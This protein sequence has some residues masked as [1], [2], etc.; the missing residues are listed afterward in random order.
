MALWTPKG[1]N[2]FNRCYSHKANTADAYVSGYFYCWI[3][4]PPIFKAG[5]SS[6]GAAGNN[7]SSGNGL[8]NTSM[9]T[10][11]DQEVLAALNPSG[12]GASSKGA[13]NVNRIEQILAA[14]CIGVPTLPADALN[15]TQTLGMNNLKAG[16]V[17]NIEVG[18]SAT[19]RFQE[20]MG[21]PFFKIFEFWKN[22]I[23]DRISGVSKLAK[24]QYTKDNFAGV[25]YY[26]TVAP[27]GIDLQYYSAMSGFWP[28]KSPTDSYTGETGTSDKLDLEIE[29]NVDKLYVGCEWIKKKIEKYQEL[30]NSARDELG[31]ENLGGI[32]NSTG[33]GDPNAKTKNAQKADPYTG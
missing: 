4:L 24:N 9:L 31:C 16:H 30:I 3:E 13:N 20:I 33:S 5:Q 7:A 21:L 17:T 22:V 10:S 2:L 26:W 29:F 27:N 18:D 6:G 32:Y 28:Q 1:A 11:M 8:L 12:S 25:A 14:G 23:R 15:K 19:I